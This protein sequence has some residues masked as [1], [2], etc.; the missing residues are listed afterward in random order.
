MSTRRMWQPWHGFNEQG[1]YCSK[2]FSSDDR[3]KP[4][5]EFSTLL[6][7]YIG[8]MDI[9]TRCVCVRFIIDYY[10]CLLALLL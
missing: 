1:E 6:Y 10:Y 2:R 7:F 8:D 3:L 5:Y 4:L 9:E